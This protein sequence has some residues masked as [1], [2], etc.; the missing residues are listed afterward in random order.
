MSTTV[1]VE[2]DG[3]LAELRDS[4]RAAVGRHRPDH[5][6]AA[7]WHAAPAN[8]QLCRQAAELGWAGLLVPERHGGAEAGVAA[9]LVV[10]D[11]LAAGL[12]KAPYLSTSVVAARILTRSTNGDLREAWLPR[13]ASGDVTVACALGH[14]GAG[15]VALTESTRGSGRQLTG[16]SGPVLDAG[17]ADLLIVAATGAAGTELFAIDP[18]AAGVRCEGLLGIDRSRD[19]GQ[20]ALDGATVSTA[21]H[22]GGE[23]LATDA[24]TIAG[25]ALAADAAGASRQALELALRYAKEREQFGRL[26]GSFQA[27]KHKLADCYIRQRAA[28]AAIAAAARALDD[29]HAAVSQ[30]VDVAL[31]YVVDAA[32]Q[33][34]GDAIQ[35]HGGVGYTWEHDAHRLWKRTKFD[36]L[37]L[38]SAAPARERLAQAAG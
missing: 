24:L 28:T 19:L 25:L 18:T 29:G 34:C 5:R 13:I 11:E 22:I 31:A 6:L 10:I 3:I 35:V 33:T 15:A 8:E 12:V 16:R 26:I 9:A 14:N 4:V 27:V 36:Q 21:Q 38:R 20:V 32:V 30:A 2:Q 17:S 7:P 37:I 1:A 23:A